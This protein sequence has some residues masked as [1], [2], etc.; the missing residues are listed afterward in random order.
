MS[1]SNI[2]SFRVLVRQ[3]LTN[4]NAHPSRYAVRTTRVLY[5]DR[6]MVTIDKAPGMDA[7]VGV[8]HL[9]EGGNDPDFPHDHS[10]SSLQNPSITSL[11]PVHRLDKATTGCLIFA[12]TRDMARELSRQFHQRRIEKTYYA[13]V[14]GGHRSFEG[15]KGTINCPIEVSRE[16]YANLRHSKDEIESETSAITE[17]EV[18]GSSSTLP[19]SLL[20][21]RMLTGRKH[22]LRVHLS[23]SLHAPILG[24]SRHSV[25]RPTDDILN[26]LRSWGVSDDRLF[27]HSSS[28]NIIRYTKSRNRLRLGIQ[29]PFPEDFSRLLR[30]LRIPFDPELSQAR[31]FLDGQPFSSSSIEELDG[32][33]FP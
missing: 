17:W 10:Q 18:V 13:V 11:F 20:K 29:A 2:T 15:S 30:H 12:R 1:Q 25:S 27:L 21:L 3:S 8:S 19:I 31:L 22:Q 9:V 5:V 33:L 14:R 28:L 26:L 16:G 4:D 6:R 23:K 24:D 7:Q 32:H